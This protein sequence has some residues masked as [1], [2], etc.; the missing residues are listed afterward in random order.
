M[1]D[2]KKDAPD[3]TNDDGVQWWREPTLTR[4][5]LSKG[6]ADMKVWT[7][8]KPDG[9]RTRLLTEGRNVLAEDQTLEGLGIKIDL[10]AF[11]RQTAG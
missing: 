1:R 10:L 11:L 3:F 9:H 8:H 6:L 2:T 4:Y 7:V 5:A